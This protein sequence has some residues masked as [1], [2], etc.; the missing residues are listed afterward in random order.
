MKQTRAS[1]ADF[2]EFHIGDSANS[3][4]YPPGIVTYKARNYE[5]AGSPNCLSLKYVTRGEIVYETEGSRISV[6]RGDLAI[7]SSTQTITGKASQTQNT[8][9]VSIFFPE[10]VAAG[11]CTQSDA[12]MHSLM[13]RAPALRGMI[14]EKLNRI[15]ALGK[16]AIAQTKAYEIVLELC[17]V[18]NNYLSDLYRVSNRFSSKKP[19]TGRDHASRMLAARKFMSQEHAFGMPVAEIAARFGF[20][21]FQFSRLFRSAFGESPA[22]YVNHQRMAAAFHRVTRDCQPLNVIAGEL[23]YGDYPTFS[24]A[25]RRFHMIGPSRMRRDRFDCS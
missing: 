21:R 6:G 8:E 15:D 1:Y 14:S 17:P 10:Q 20:T 9:G 25:F 22:D 5:V 12:F 19:K 18:V 2:S 11:F 24:K 16:S 4:T 7:V 23:G 3:K 13:C